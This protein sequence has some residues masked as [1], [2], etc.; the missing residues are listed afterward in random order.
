MA[1]IKSLGNDKYRVF[2]CRTL[3]D[4]TLARPS[5][6]IYAKSMT[7]AKRQANALEADFLRENLN[8]A[9]TAPK[10]PLTFQEVVTKWRDI[11]SHKLA[12]KTQERYE[13]I[14]ADFLLP[15]F[16][17]VPIPQISTGDIREYIASLEK[18]GVRKDGKPGGY[19]EKTIKA[20]Y[21]L[22]QRIFSFA[23]EM[24]YIEKSP[25]T[26][27]KAPKVTKKEARYMEPENIDE[28]FT[29]LERM[30]EGTKES[31]SNSIKYAKMDPDEMNRR[32][33]L[34]LFIDMMH[35]TYA[36]LALVT[37]GRRSEI[38]GLQWS[39]FDFEN[40]V[41][42]IRRTLQYTSS[43]GL[44]FESTLKNGEP[45]KP[46]PLPPA[47]VEKLMRYKECQERLLEAMGWRDN[48]FV[49]ISIKGST[50][51]TPGGPIMPDTI[52]RWFATFLENYGLKKISL[53]GLRHS[54]ISFLLNN[55]VSVEAAASIAG[56]NPTVTREIYEHIY[57]DTK[58]EAVKA[59]DSLLSGKI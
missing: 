17:S 38:S 27:L 12:T 58:R 52:S 19:S 2:L 57:M 6:V 3:P 41:M 30:C 22:F 5:K 7:E 45:V 18:D 48:G 1:S 35:Q 15:R 29:A 33:Q 50:V 55:G 53:H 26:H 23:L 59:F 49:F 40:R 16:G 25:F 54:C 43:R 39:D 36:W 51:T 21:M 37:G 46:T 20:H 4:G 24:E 56:H 34:R 14:L 31:F 9:H 8:E 44:Y 28:M 10:T 11:D 32:Q 47:M 13:G 42:V